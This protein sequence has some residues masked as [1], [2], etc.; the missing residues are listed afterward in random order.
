[1][2]FVSDI[3]GAVQIIRV[4]P[5]VGAEAVAGSVLLKRVG[6]QSVVSAVSR[7]AMERHRAGYRF[8]P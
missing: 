7:I 1:M 3:S 4:G 8:Q 2:R 5:S 6:L